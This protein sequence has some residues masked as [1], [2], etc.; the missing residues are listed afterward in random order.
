MNVLTR[1]EYID[2]WNERDPDLVEPDGVM[3]F[4]EAESGIES[5]WFFWSDTVAYNHIIKDRDYF[6][7]WCDQNLQGSVTCYS[8]GREG[9]WWGFTDRDDIVLWVLKWT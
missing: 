1:Q 4:W 5:K 3:W 9:E 6:W 2:Y 8:S 7:R